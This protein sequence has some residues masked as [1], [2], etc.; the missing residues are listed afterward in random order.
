MSRHMSIGNRHG[1]VLKRKIFVGGVNPALGNDVLKKY[2]SNFG[3]VEDATI[4]RYS[5]GR[6]RGFGFVVFLNEAT[7]TQVLQQRTHPVT[8]HDKVEVKPCLSR[9]KTRPIG[10]PGVGPFGGLMGMTPGAYDTYPPPHSGNYKGTYGP[11]RGGGPPP[12]HG[13]NGPA[14][15]YG[16]Y[17]SHDYNRCGY[18]ASRS[19]CPG[20]SAN[21]IAGYNGNCGASPNE[22]SGYTGE[23]GVSNVSVPHSTRPWMEGYRDEGQ[24][25]E[26]WRDPYDP[27]YSS[28]EYYGQ[29]NPNASAVPPSSIPQMPVNTSVGPRNTH[30]SYQNIAQPTSSVMSSTPQT[31]PSSAAWMN[32]EGFFDVSSFG[33]NDPRGGYTGRNTTVPCVIR[34]NSNN[35]P[36]RSGSGSQGSVVSSLNMTNMQ[37]SN[38]GALGN[39]SGLRRNGDTKYGVPGG[40]GYAGLNNFQRNA[41]Y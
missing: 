38:D 27:T 40:A 3:P 25:Y 23:N 28:A 7:C 18:G 39:F 36:S 2:F 8:P 10:V 24:P 19:G 15:P 37:G 11:Y 41:P 29:D 17:N 14:A 13:A 35:L 31:T 34:H 33:M 1:V 9:S 6:S 21:S 22:Y 16:G 32:R 12:P 30:G 26:Y 5:D 4:M 20:E